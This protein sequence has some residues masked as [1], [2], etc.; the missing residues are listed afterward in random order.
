[1]NKQ[2]LVYATFFFL[3]TMQLCAVPQSMSN[4][5]QAIMQRKLLV[6]KICS[7]YMAS[8]IL[9]GCVGATTGSLVRYMEKRLN[10]ESS[11]VALFLLLLGWAFESE[12]RNDIILGLQKELD[13]YQ[14]EHKKGLMFKSAWIASW[15][16]YLQT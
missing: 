15:L 1:M 14:V 11:P 5:H 4:I 9:S 12:F 8:L 7:S 2:I 16:G 3:A 6:R 10:I 13:Y